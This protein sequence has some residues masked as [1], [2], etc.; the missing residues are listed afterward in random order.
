MNKSERAVQIWPLLT[1]SAT[2]R[3][4]LSYDML[5]RLIGVP[6][7]GLGQLLE[8]IQ[9]FCILRKLPAL[10]SLVVSEVSGM[11]GEGFIA[12]ADVPAEQARVFSEQWLSR[13]VPT[14]EDLETAVR[15]LPS[16]GRSLAELLRARDA[17]RGPQT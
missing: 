1:L 9:S 4:V 16:S 15:A 5:S 17:L 14:P 8:P 10:T 3:H 7:P 6:R 11:P 13:G 2:Y 12:S